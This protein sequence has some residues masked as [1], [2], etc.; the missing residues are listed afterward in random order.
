MFGHQAE[1][2]PFSGMSMWGGGWVSMSTSCTCVLATPMNGL[3]LG[4]AHTALCSQHGVDS[5]TDAVERTGNTGAQS[6]GLSTFS[7]AA[8]MA[9]TVTMG[10]A[11]A[12]WAPP[13][14]GQARAFAQ[15]LA[16]RR[17]AAAL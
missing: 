14:S 15:G 11:A 17:Q 4:F 8:W 10:G 13:F 6:L 1:A 5:P 7:T 2:P 12:P 16:T 9:Q 3:G